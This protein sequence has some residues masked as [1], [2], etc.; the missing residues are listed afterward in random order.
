[1]QTRTWAGV[2]EGSLGAL[3]A[4]VF[5]NLQETDVA[6]VRTICH[7][8]APL[9]HRV[10][11]DAVV[12]Q[13]EHSMRCSEGHLRIG[14]ARTCAPHLYVPSQ[15]QRPLMTSFSSKPLKRKIQPS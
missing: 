9:R 15:E 10:M 6:R 3:L 5:H 4:G 2:H 7:F 12:F 11:L 14:L 13:H 1:M 8:S